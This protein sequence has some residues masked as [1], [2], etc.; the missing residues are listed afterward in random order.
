MENE[1][2]LRTTLSYGL[3]DQ[4]PIYASGVTEQGLGYS[5]VSIINASVWRVKYKKVLN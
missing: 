4:A 2:P 3:C 5:Q 1:D